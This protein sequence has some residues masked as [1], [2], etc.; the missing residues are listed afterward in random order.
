MLGRLV[1]LSLVVHGHL[2]AAFVGQGYCLPFVR[3]GVVA[4]RAPFFLVELDVYRRRVALLV[5][6]VLQTD[7]LAGYV[8]GFLLFRQ[9]DTFPFAD[10]LDVAVLVRPLAVVLL[11]IL[12]V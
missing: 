3:V 8:V 10:G 6:D 2:G 11:F 4:E 12:T 7:G 5:G 9:L 1:G